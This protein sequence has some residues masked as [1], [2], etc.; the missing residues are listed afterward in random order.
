MY[1]YTA[2]Q[3][4]YCFG[5]LKI[6]LS[7]L[8]ASIKPCPVAAQPQHPVRMT[9]KHK[10]MAMKKSLFNFLHSIPGKI[11]LHFICR[12]DKQMK[13]PVFRSVQVPLT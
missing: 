6:S 11:D 5:A 12:I 8:L 4:A 7:D 10:E 9:E 2:I 1:V 13:P 3:S